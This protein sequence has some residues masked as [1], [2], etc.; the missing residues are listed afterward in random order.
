MVGAM[1]EAILITLA[2]RKIPTFSMAAGVQT[3]CIGRPH[4]LPLVST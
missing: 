3:G 2:K 1:D 4:V